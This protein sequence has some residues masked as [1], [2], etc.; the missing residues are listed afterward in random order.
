MAGNVKLN[1]LNELEGFIGAALVDTNSG[2]ALGLLGGGSLNMEVAAAGNTE[3][4]RAKRRAGASLGIT[5]AIDDVLIT[6]SKQYHLIRPLESNQDLFL[7]VVLDR[8]RANLAMAR[9]ELKAFEQT[10][11]FK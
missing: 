2:M 5:D 8:S 1:K 10:L 4:V 11:D 7:Y 6:L 3:V 9:H